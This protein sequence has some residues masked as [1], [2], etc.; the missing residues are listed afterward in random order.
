M[1][2][3]PSLILQIKWKCADCKWLVFNGLEPAE[4]QQKGRRQSSQQY[5]ARIR[6]RKDARLAN[7]SRHQI[8]L[9]ECEAIAA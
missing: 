1:R 4:T 5:N 8:K 7:L 2:S 3:I 6:P 9:S